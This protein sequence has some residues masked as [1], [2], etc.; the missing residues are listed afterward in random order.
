ETL[1]SAS[2]NIAQVV[3]QTLPATPSNL[4]AL[5]N[6][7]EIQLNWDHDSDNTHTVIVERQLD[8][9]GWQTLATLGNVSSHTDASLQPGREHQYRV[10]SRNNQGDSAP[11]NSASV[12]VSEL[13]AAPSNLTAQLD[14]TYV[15]LAWTNNASNADSL[16]VQRQIDGGS[17][18]DIATLAADAATYVDTATLVGSHHAYQV[19]ARNSIGDSAAS[20]QASLLVD[21]VPAAPTNL[22]AQLDG[23]SVNLAWT[24]N[25]SNADSLIVQRQIDGG[26][27]ADIATLAGDAATYVDT[28]T[29]VGSHHGYQVIGRNSIGDSAAS[30]QA[31]LLVDDVPAAPSNLTAQLDGT[32]VNLAW[33]NNASNADN[34]IVQRQIGSGGWN[35]IATLE[36]GA[37]SHSDNATQLGNTHSYRVLA[38]NAIGSSGTSNEASLLVDVLPTAPTSLNAQLDATQVSLSWNNQADNADQI[39]IERQLD[40]GPWQPLASMAANASS[41]TDQATQYGSQHSYRV[42][43]VNTLGESPPSNTAQVLVLQPPSPPT[44]LQAQSNH[45]TVQLRWDANNSPYVSAL[46]LERQ[47]LGGAWQPVATL[48]AAANRYTDEGLNEGSY[49]YRLIAINPAG[50][51]SA[52]VS[53]EVVILLPPAA[54]TDFQAQPQN[55][56]VVLLWTDNADNEFGFRIERQERD[57]ETWLSWQAVAELNADVTRYTDN[58][59]TPG[60]SY[61]YRIRS[62]NSAGTSTPTAALT[63]SLDNEQT[64]TGDDTSDDSL[65]GDFGNAGGSVSILVALLGILGLR[66]RRGASPC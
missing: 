59:V 60:S 18:A 22:T 42:I 31:T 35:D 12:L 27:W 11:S 21:T 37:V 26:T 45:S 49:R 33:T 25:A 53:E 23:T 29:Q 64:P 15:N 34:L 51:S 20:N 16:I 48:A 66:R 54:P 2:S 30:N 5:Q 36:G 28:A 4:T 24:N 10:I 3:Y 41:Y 50:E 56:S 1:I 55:R 44:G 62:L 57:G 8:N 39:R 65:P 32:S 47:R 38:R 17:W 52:S 46:R 58:H 7:N 19:I 6:G 43:A 13:P 63:V 9:D 40:S 14:G 61:R